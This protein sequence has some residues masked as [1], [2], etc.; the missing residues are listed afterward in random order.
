MIECAIFILVKNTD[1]NK[2]PNKNLQVQIINFVSCGHE[3]N[4]KTKRVPVNH[5]KYIKGY[6]E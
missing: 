6:I 5:E 3:Q 4:K 1:Y 2:I